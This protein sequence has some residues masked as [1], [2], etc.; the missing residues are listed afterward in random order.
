M[1]G[2]G[3]KTCECLDPICQN[4]VTTECYAVCYWLT[5]PPGLDLSCD[6][7]IGMP[8]AKED[9][10]NFDDDCDLAI[11]ED[12][13]AG[14]YTGP[15][16]TVGVGICVPG[17]MTCDSGVWGSYTEQNLFMPGLC[18]GEITPQDE[19]CNG[20][21]DDCD[22]SVRQLQAVCDQRLDDRDTRYDTVMQQLQ[23]VKAQHRATVNDL[24]QCLRNSD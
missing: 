8:L 17:E 13:F 4:I 5:D 16:G 2:K 15:S 22:D 12:I 19:L 23:D 14:C 10:N 9:C 20:L 24:N 6:P 11:D 1:C 21:D 3:Y 7:T 18:E